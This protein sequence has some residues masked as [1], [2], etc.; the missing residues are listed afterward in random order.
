MHAARK[1][2][3]PGRFKNEYAH[4]RR[5]EGDDGASQE[6][7]D[8]YES[9]VNSQNCQGDAPGEGTSRRGF[10]LFLGTGAS[11]KREVDVSFDIAAVRGTVG[12]GSVS[13]GFH[14]VPPDASTVGLM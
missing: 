5:N 10:I 9:V 7:T 11:G 14:Q 3:G 12:G 8:Q 13:K 2:N 1:R 6:R 4:T